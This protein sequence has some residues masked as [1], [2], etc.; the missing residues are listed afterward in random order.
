MIEPLRQFF[1]I[2]NN[3]QI[4]SNEPKDSLGSLLVFNQSIAGL[5]PLFV[6]LICDALCFACVNEKKVVIL[7]YF[8]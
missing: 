5:F 6:R 8:T 2:K 1:P 7:Q 4:Q 3:I